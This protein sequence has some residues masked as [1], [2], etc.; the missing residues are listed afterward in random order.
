MTVTTATELKKETTEA[1]QDLIRINIDSAK[2]YREAA[3]NVDYPVFE[4]WLKSNAS[5][6]DEFANEL[7]GFVELSDEEARDSGSMKGTF[8]RWWMNLKTTL[9][10]DNVESVLSEAIRGEEAIKSEYESAIRDTTGNPVNDVLHKQLNSIVQAY[11]DVQQLH[12]ARQAT[13]A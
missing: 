1:L 13:S 8:H 10:S 3:D 5:Q 11:R 9:S 12:D 4:S 6:R 2:G 7:Q